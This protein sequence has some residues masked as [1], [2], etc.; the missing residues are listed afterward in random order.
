MLFLEKL[1]LGSDVYS[2]IKKRGSEFLNHGF[3]SHT[4]FIQETHSTL[5]IYF[6]IS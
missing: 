6:M 2:N 3:L 1:R 5:V 4:T